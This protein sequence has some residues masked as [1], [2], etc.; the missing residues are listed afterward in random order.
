VIIDITL[1]A[2]GSLQMNP[3]STVNKY[4]KQQTMLLKL[5]CATKLRPQFLKHFSF[6]AMEGSECVGKSDD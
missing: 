4:E 1:D 2:A 3:E 6:L 5:D